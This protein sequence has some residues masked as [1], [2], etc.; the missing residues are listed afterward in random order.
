MPWQKKA[1]N[2]GPNQ[3][4]MG[5]KPHP[6]KTTKRNE[7]NL[8]LSLYMGYNFFF[9]PIETLNSYVSRWG[10]LLHAL[11]HFVFWGDEGHFSFFFCVKWEPWKESHPFFFYRW[12]KGS[13][14]SVNPEQNPHNLNLL[15]YQI[16]ADL[17]E[18]FGSQWMD[19]PKHEGKRK[20]LIKRK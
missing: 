5:P 4:T 8:L 16:D 12:S 11:S 15:W 1:E 19:V 9:F 20:I 14:K 17:R 2:Q 6:K 18:L 3:K 10:S 7:A 13:F